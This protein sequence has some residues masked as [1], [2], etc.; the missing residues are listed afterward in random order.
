M[1]LFEYPRAFAN[2]TLSILISIMRCNYSS[3]V[4]LTGMQEKGNVR[5]GR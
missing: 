4:R 3:K 2:S 1:G 5:F